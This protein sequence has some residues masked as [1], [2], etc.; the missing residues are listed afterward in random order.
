MDRA[1]AIPTTMN[2]SNGDAYPGMEFV[3][4]VD[5]VE[6]LAVGAPHRKRW[7]VTVMVSSV[8]STKGPI[9]VG[10]HVAILMH[11]PAQAFR[12]PTEE[13]VGRKFSIRLFDDFAQNYSG[14]F[15]I[16]A[17]IDDEE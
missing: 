7:V 16:Q 11:S 2:E 3:G 15:E 13:I 10:D 17:P 5:A 9:H 6:P 12:L 14:R 8:R 4:R 1:G